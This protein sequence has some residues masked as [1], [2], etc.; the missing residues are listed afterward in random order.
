MGG[1]ANDA[2]IGSD[3]RAPTTALAMIAMADATTMARA[4]VATTTGTTSVSPPAMV[5]AAVAGGAWCGR[6]VAAVVGVLGV[7]GVKVDQP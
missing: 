4:E 7:V 1:V 6:V 5:L 3:P 2:M